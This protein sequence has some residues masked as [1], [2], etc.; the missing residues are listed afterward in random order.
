MALLPVS[1]SGASPS[2]F[3][4][5]QSSATSFIQTNTN[6]GHY[7]SDMISQTVHQSSAAEST[8]TAALTGSGNLTGAVTAVAQ[9]QLALQTSVA[10]RDRV[11]SAYQSIMNMPI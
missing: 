10:I 5:G 4:L 6:F 7:V 2:L 11:I 1:L 9:A 8:A 3:T